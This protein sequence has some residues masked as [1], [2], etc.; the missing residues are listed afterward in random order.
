MEPTHANAGLLQLAPLLLI[1]ISVGFCA[2]ALARD[3]GR[4]VG[5][6]TVLGFI[7]FLNLFV[8]WFFMG[9]SN[10]R[11]ERKVDALLKAQGVDPTTF[12]NP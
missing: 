10:L 12:S 5:V 11:L 4:D 9:A 6:W 8:V 1:S 3:K 7:P 2:R